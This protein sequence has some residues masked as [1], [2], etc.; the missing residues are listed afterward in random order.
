MPAM[1]KVADNTPHHPIGLG[2]LCITANTELGY[3]M[4]P[5]FI[6]QHYLL[7]SSHPVILDPNW[8]APQPLLTLP[9]QIALLLFIIVDEDHKMFVFRLQ[10]TGAFSILQHCINQVIL[11][12]LLFHP[13][14]PCMSM[15]FSG[16][17]IAY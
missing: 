10:L 8:V 12:T 13:C 14:H 17:I 4:A 9:I 11:I 5:T 16:L 2:F 7:L 3:I 6:R 1:L 15:K